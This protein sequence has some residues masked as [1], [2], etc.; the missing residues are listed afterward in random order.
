MVLGL[1]QVERRR[2]L[3][4]LMLTGLTE[5]KIGEILGVS[6]RTVRRDLKSP[7]VKEFA[8]ELLRTQL[9]DITTADPK[10]RLYYRDK[11]L[12]KLIKRFGY[13]FN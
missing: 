7:Q 13:I 2:R 12:G 9:R 6:D 4:E 5:K 8:L 1:K 3:I 11:L 10:T